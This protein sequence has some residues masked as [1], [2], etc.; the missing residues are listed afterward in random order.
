M[1]LDAILYGKEEQ[2]GTIITMEEVRR[3]SSR[4]ESKKGQLLGVAEIAVR[5]SGG[6]L[7]LECDEGGHF[8]K[9]DGVR[10]G[11]DIEHYEGFSDT[12]R[13]WQ[14][15][16]LRFTNDVFKVIRDKLPANHAAAGAVLF[17][18]GEQAFP[19]DLISSW[20]KIFPN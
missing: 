12:V 16:L 14:V 7:T 5:N 19:G 11:L 3:T 18:I 9:L 20:K 1:G 13:D 6:R 15:G 4:K 2:M 17:K 10:I 8:L